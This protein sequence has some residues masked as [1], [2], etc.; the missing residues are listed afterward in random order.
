MQPNGAIKPF[1]FFAL[2]ACSAP[3]GDPV[4]DDIVP[5]RISVLDI[6][7]GDTIRIAGQ[8]P[9]S[10]LS[11]RLVGYDTP[12]TFEPGCEQERQLGNAATQRLQ[13]IL[14]D[15]GD[16]NS[17][18]QGF[19]RFSRA[20][21][22]LKVDGVDLADIMVSEGLAVRYQGGKRINWCHRLAAS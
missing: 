16:I 22:R 13:V 6:I 20:L 1:V 14:R 9:G 10:T 3:V 15:A 19:D 5:N 12:E 18:N 17:E 11:A 4:L 7:D 8:A 2:V 21:L